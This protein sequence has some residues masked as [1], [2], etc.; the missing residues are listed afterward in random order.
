MKVFLCWIFGH[1]IT[2]ELEWTGANGGKV[3]IVTCDSCPC[4][5]VMSDHHK[6]FLRYD[7]DPTFAEDV[8]SLYPNVRN[9]F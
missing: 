5:W 3:R 1:K 7:N 8:K 4:R 2:S 6:A 9:W